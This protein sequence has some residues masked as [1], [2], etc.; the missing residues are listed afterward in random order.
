MNTSRFLLVFLAFLTVSCGK[1]YDAPPTISTSGYDGAGTRHI[2]KVGSPGTVT[3]ILDEKL[4]LARA[5]FTTSPVSFR[6]GS[7]YVVGTRDGKVAVFSPEDS[8]LAI[9]TLVS[10]SPVLELLVDSSSV[11]VIQT[12]GH[13]TYLPKDRTHKRTIFASTPALCNSIFTGE[14]LII[15][16]DLSVIMYPIWRSNEH[17]STRYTLYPRSLA[18]DKDA[19]L[20]YLAL[21]TNSSEGADSILCISEDG[22]I[23]SR[24]GFPNMRISSNLTLVGQENK[25]V[26]F[27]YFGD[28]NPQ[29][30][31]RRTYVALYEGIAEGKP[32]QVAKQEIPYI[33]MNIA[34]NGELIISS[35]FRERSEEL[36]SGIDAFD[37]SSL[38]KRWQRRFSEPLVAPVSIS[39]EN[40]YFTLSFPTTAET[41]SNGLFYV[42]TAS[43]G[44]TD[45]EVAIEGVLSGFAAGMPMP[46]REDAL[47]LSDN[48]KPI[49]YIIRD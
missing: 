2:P 9:D 17:I 31:V 6:D 10:E 16:T 35:G 49:I 27:G 21:T 37:V 25:R 13:I 32:K 19:K 39:A 4:T 46:F 40:I 23:I 42:L 11:V 48:Q 33:P 1:N 22:R 36:A 45:R 44:K 24:T 15:A 41:P 38:E 14:K 29:S 47:M 43:T 30:S 7:G 18:Y 20:I 3:K 26:A 28:L 12:D 34:S 5:E 8:L